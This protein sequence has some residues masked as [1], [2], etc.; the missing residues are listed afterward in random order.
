MSK[1]HWFAISYFW[2]EVGR[3]GIANSFAGVKH[4]Y[5]TLKDIDE[6]KGTTG[7]PSTA[8]VLS[9]AYIGYMTKETFIGTDE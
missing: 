9:C 7:A 3:N 2:S 8:S 5:I 4:K 6:N 1:R